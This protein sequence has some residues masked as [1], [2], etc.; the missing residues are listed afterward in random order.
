MTKACVA[1]GV[2]MAGVALL[3]RT[4]SANCNIV[5]QTGISD[6]SYRGKKRDVATL[7]AAVLH[8]MGFHRGNDGKKYKNVKAHFV[9][10]PNG[11]IVQN[12]PIDY[13]LP[14][15]NGIS[16]LSVAIEFAGNFKSV[17]N[18][19]DY[20][21]T[22][23]EHVPSQA[24]YASGRCLLYYL[25]MKMPKFTHVLAHRQSGGQRQND[26]GP[27][28]WCNVGEWALRY[29]GLKDGGPGFKVGDGRTIDP[30]W[31]TWCSL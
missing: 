2:A 30:K 20:S 28:I 10:L 3:P 15:S 22:S 4:A 14:A 8:Q 5:D 21:N 18:K 27:E 25:R 13:Y 26:P 11:T 24:Q 16:A 6:H 9:V 29:M 23:A 1:L 31:R 7:T 19:W 17:R 12:H